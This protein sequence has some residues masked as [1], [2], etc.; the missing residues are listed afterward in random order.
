MRLKL[1]IPGHWMRNRR[2]KLVYREQR[3]INLKQ[4]E[5]PQGIRLDKSSGKTSFNGY[6]AKQD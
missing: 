5:T 6:D 3:V 1:V 2:G 4:H